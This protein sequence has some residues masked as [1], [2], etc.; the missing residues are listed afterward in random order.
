MIFRN[1]Q[2]TEGI[3][4]TYWQFRTKKHAKSRMLTIF[5][6]ESINWVKQYTSYLYKVKKHVVLK[7][8]HHFDDYEDIK[9]NSSSFTHISE[10]EKF[11]TDHI[12]V[13]ILTTSFQTT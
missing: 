8:N 13:V 10:I 6:T 5:G 9:H 12:K 4:H 7:G 2:V 3:G 11:T 1:C